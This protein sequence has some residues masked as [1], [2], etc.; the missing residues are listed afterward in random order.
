MPITRI[1]KYYAVVILILLIIISVVG[2][3]MPENR[4]NKIKPI[5]IKPIP[6]NLTNFTINITNP[7]NITNIT[8]FNITNPLNMTNFTINITNPLNITNITGI[9]ITDFN[10]TNPLNMTNF[11][12]NITNPINITNITEIN[13]T[14]DL[15]KSNITINETKNESV[16]LAPERRGAVTTYFYANGATIAKINEEELE[17]LHQDRLGS[18]INSKSLPFGQEIIKGDRFSFTGKELDSNLHYFSARYYDSNLGKFTS[19]DPIKENH[20]YSYVDN[21]PLKFTDPT[22][23]VKKDKNQNVVMNS[24]AMPIKQTPLI[25][26]FA[27]QKEVED[28]KKNIANPFVATSN[29]DTTGAQLYLD[30]G[31]GKPISIPRVGESTV[32]PL[33]DVNMISGLL[34]MEVRKDGPIENL[35]LIAHRNAANHKEIV[36]SN[37]AN[38]ADTNTPMADLQTKIL[39]LPQNYFATNSQII[40]SICGA[41]K[42]MDGQA[43]ADK[44]KVTT[45]I[46]SEK[47]EYIEGMDP[48]LIYGQFNKY[49]PV[50]K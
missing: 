5:N 17:Y 7:I 36:L 11:T 20:P 46:T 21:N 30:I 49:T 27:T 50:K 15:T 40:I 48:M 8:D 45:Y 28:Y 4:L 39:N 12:I 44:L 2:A 1:M 38:T 10:I 16:L 34:S 33:I 6:V 35:V 41:D 14:I 19:T 18:D 24:R 31:N 13:Q 43:I 22:G 37:L 47:V 3:E 26:T 25:L 23:M 9:N 42:C 29:A 32:F